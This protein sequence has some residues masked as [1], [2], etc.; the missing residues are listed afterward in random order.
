MGKPVQLTEAHINAITSVTNCCTCGSQSPFVEHH[1]PDCQHR[2]LWELYDTL[3][4]STPVGWTEPHRGKKWFI[5]P[6]D[7]VQEGTELTPVYELPY[8]PDN[9]EIA[10]GDVKFWHLMYEEMGSTRDAGFKEAYKILDIEDDGEY[11]WKW[12][13]LELQALKNNYDH[14]VREIEDGSSCC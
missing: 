9:P 10:G 8:A 4:S 2:L 12:L 14:A 11:R 5:N 7:T 6:G 1:E 3:K 13:L